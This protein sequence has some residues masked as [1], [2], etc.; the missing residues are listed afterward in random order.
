M[1]HTI[2][3]ENFEELVE[4]SDK[5]VMLDFW[6]GWCGPCRMMAPV[7]QALSEEREDVFFG[8]VNVDEEE[9][10]ARKFN[11]LSIPTFLVFKGGEVVS[12]I[13]GARQ[14]SALEELL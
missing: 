4:K 2:T 5:T 1:V 8:K 7:V 3:S 11:I 13:A 9:A 10:L 14:R 12:R 6:A